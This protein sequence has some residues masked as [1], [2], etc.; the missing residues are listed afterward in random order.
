MRFASVNLWSVMVDVAG[1]DRPTSQV[2]KD[3]LDFVAAGAFG[4]GTEITLQVY[5]EGTWKLKIFSHEPSNPDQVTLTVN[6]NGRA[7]VERN[8]TI[9]DV[10]DFRSITF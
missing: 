3:L 2:C 8:K 9:G 1:E 7:H 5:E 4:F 6:R 10:E